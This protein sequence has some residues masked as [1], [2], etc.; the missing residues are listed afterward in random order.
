MTSAPSRNSPFASNEP[1]SRPRWGLW[2][3]RTLS[4]PANASSGRNRPGLDLLFVCAH[5]IAH[6]QRRLSGCVLMKLRPVMNARGAQRARMSTRR[7]STI[8]SAA[9]SW[10][11]CRI[12]LRLRRKH[13]AYKRGTRARTRARPA[14][15][16]RVSRSRVCVFWHVSL[17]VCLAR[18]ALARHE[19]RIFTRRAWRPLT[20]ECSV[21]V[22]IY[23]APTE[24]G[25][26]GPRRL[27]T[28][29]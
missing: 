6:A 17:H 5:M 1:T 12:G 3:R 15:S 16:R 27:L 10:D 2:E 26:D 14:R 8:T 29:E 23:R 22:R 21:V 28:C 19:T 24:E 11:V 4:V 7:P 25:H 20:I 9:L 13:H 18:Q